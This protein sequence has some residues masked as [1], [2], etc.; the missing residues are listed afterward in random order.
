MLKHIPEC[1]N[2][3]IHDTGLIE[4]CYEHT[5]S[6]PTDT[7]REVQ[8]VYDK[9]CGYMIVTLT[10]AKENYRK[11]KRVHRLLA[12][13]FIPNPENK[14]HV[15]HIDGNKLNIALENLEWATPAENT[16]HAKETGLLDSR[17]KAL[18]KPIEQLNLD[19]I[20][21]NAFVS[22]HAI[23]RETGICW[24]NVYKVC[25]GLRKTAGG[26]RWQYQ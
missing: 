17:T 19:G 13:A 3:R 10:D 2:Y 22:L 26:Y 15:N 6:I 4:S 20:V 16:T 8:P 11:N 9:S 12:E 23:T 5:T 7:W 18:E 14:A 25:N 1:P 21:I 24:Q